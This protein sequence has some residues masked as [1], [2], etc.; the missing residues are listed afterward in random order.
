MLS[1]KQG[2]I[3]YLSSNNSM[4]R[5]IRLLFILLLA[6]SVHPAFA[7]FRKYTQWT[8]DGNGYYDE[9]GNGGIEKVDIKTGKITPL[10]TG[11]LLIPLGRSYPLQIASFS[12]SADG[13]KILIFTNAAKVWRYK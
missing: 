13:T 11:D 7:Q 3:Y 9:D 4:Q 5:S 10:I 6:A 2:V 1:F 8:T 12:F